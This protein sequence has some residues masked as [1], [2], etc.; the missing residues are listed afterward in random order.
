M[1]IC[2]LTRFLKLISPI[3]QVGGDRGAKN[4][5]GVLRKR[6]VTELEYIIDEG[7]PIVK[8]MIPGIK[9]NIAMS[10]HS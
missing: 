7:M 3:I 8:N 10:V 9:E 5:A 2:Q 4:L 1:E 6:G